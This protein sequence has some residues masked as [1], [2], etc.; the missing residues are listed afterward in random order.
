MS[1]RPTT[2][3]RRQIAAEMLIEAGYDWEAPGDAVDK[4]CELA[5]LPR[6]E[7]TADRM[8]IWDLLPVDPE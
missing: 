1:G 4:A 3:E 8:P 6:P 2:A 5:G 7:S